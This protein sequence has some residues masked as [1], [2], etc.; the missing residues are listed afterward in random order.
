MEAQRGTDGSEPGIAGPRTGDEWLRTRPLEEQLTEY[1]RREAE[2]VAE[3]LG[4]YE[5]R[6]RIVQWQ[7]YGS[8][9]HAHAMVART[10]T[11][12]ASTS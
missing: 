9:A 11:R 2:D 8:R 1:D 4:D 10:T 12:S 5:G 7:E 6:H 3:V